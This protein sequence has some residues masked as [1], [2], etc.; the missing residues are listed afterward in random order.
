MPHLRA[1]AALGA[2]LLAAPAAAE[3]FRH[4]SGEWREYNRDWLAACPVRI[5]ED[6]PDYYGT[7]C[8][9]STGSAELNAAGLPAYKLTLVRNRLD[10]TLDVAFTFAPTD[11]AELDTARPLRIRFG[12]EPDM[13]FAF[14]TDLETRHNVVNQ[15]FV[16][17]EARR[18]ALIAAMRARNAAT[19]L[20]PVSGVSEPEREV[21]LSMRGVL[22]S[23]DFMESH[24]RR[25]DDYD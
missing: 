7:S 12:G 14:S 3:P 16:A 11:G 18:D 17:D 1:F 22:A 4:S 6:S 24:A 8:F 21:W 13:A 2:L 20:V 15:F 10:G 25:V 5:V 23:L 9:A 19:L